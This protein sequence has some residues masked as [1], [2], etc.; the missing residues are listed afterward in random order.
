MNAS[1]NAAV[2]A[3]A[4]AIVPRLPTDRWRAIELAFWLLPVAAF[5]LFP[6]HRVL[7]SQIL[8]TGLFAVTLDLITDRAAML[9]ELIEMARAA[10]GTAVATAPRMGRTRACSQMRPTKKML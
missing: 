2:W 10:R 5:F 4:A 3:P 9:S 6:N 1:G 7:G 8:I